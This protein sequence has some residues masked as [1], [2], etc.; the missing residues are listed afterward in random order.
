MQEILVL[1]YSQHGS[2]KQMARL[3]ARGIKSVNGVDA[4]I[5]TVPN[6]HIIGENLTQ[7]KETSASDPYVTYLDLEECVGLALGSP[8]YFGNMASSLKHFWDTTTSQW[9]QG[10]LAGK[11]ACAF[12][13]SGSIHGGQ[14]TCLWSM[15]LPLLH[16]GM[17]IVGIPYTNSALMSTTTGGTPYGTSHYAGLDDD[18][19]FSDQE[20]HLA[21]S[22]GKLLAQTA[23]KLNLDLPP[24]ATIISPI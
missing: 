9:L 2:T 3:I 11:P 23:V 18:N 19:T 4:R 10:V 6:V 16:H 12:T 14:E 24:A 20:K 13:S 1:Y 22:Q 17:V 15:L 7:T 8:V 21:I 5:R